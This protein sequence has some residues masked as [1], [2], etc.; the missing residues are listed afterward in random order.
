M[1]DTL[2]VFGAKYLF[3]LIAGVALVYLLRQPR[4]EQ[5]RMVIF[6][7]LTLPLT[8]LVSKVGGMLYFDPRPS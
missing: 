1:L 6:G 2:S 8:Y 4:A 3:L 5:K 7:A